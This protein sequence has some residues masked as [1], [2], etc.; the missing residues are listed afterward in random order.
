MCRQMAYVGPALT[1]ESLVLA[2]EHSLLHQSY[3]PKFQRHG[4]VNADGF[5][6]G[7]FDKSV[8]PEPAI[9]RNSKPIWSD[10]SF[11]GIAGLIRS[12]AVMAAVRD[13][14]AGSFV[15]ESSTAPFHEG[16]WLF[17]H[18]GMFRNFDEAPGVALR[19]SVSDKRYAAIRGT[20]DSEFLFAL[21]LDRID[22]G[23]DVRD[24]M[25]SVISR[26]L[27]VSTGTFNFLLH[28]GEKITASACGDSLYYLEA[29]ERFAG[30]MIIASEPFDSGTGWREVPEGSLVEGSADG[31][32]VSPLAAFAQ[33]SSPLS[34]RQELS[35]ASGKAAV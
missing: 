21:I 15:E 27:Q 24:A 6:C 5:G 2:P 11:A 12:S 14:T 17:A 33:A 19:R 25:A 35:V 23:M 18:N 1:L 22:E 4:L 28:D 9:Y 8:R 32:T 10:R 13:A 29:N 7:W 34:S 3:K 26:C 31:V 16:R 20:S 30:G